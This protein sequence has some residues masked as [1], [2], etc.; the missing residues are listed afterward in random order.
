[1]CISEDLDS[2]RDNP[3]LTGQLPEF[4][5]C[6]ADSS[7]VLHVHRSFIR[8]YDGRKIP[9]VEACPGSCVAR[10]ANLVNLDQQCVTVAVQCSGFD[11]L[12]VAGGIALAPI[13]LAGA[14]IERDPA[15]GKRPAKGFG[16]HPAQHQDFTG[17]ELLDNCSNQSG[18]VRFQ[19]EPQPAVL[20]D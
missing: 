3:A 19:F 9:S 18:C 14:R 12:D 7:K 17:V 11:P 6:R 5:E 8:S 13:R 15:A 10:R 1:M 20:I 2:D 16:I 4:V